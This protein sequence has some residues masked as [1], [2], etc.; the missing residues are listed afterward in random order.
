[1]CKQILRRETLIAE[2]NAIV[3]VDID[4]ASVGAGK[5]MLMVCMSGTAIKIKNPEIVG[6]KY[7]E[8][9]TS[10]KEMYERISYLNVLKG[11]WNCIASVGNGQI[12]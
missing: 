4:Y 9:L 1:M 11:S 12:L 7:V 10:I 6:S 3:A 8:A 2:G 5:G